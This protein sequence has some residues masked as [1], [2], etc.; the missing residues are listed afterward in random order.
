MSYK[1]G[2]FIYSRHNEIR[3]ITAKMLD[4]VCNDVRREPSLIKLSGEVLQNKTS[5]TKDE[6]RLDVSATGFWSKSQKVFLD[7]RVFD[8]NV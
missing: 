2:G 6:A 4:E 8:P 7:M 1:I 5:N 3:D